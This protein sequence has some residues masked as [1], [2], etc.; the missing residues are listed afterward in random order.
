MTRLPIITFIF[1]LAVAVVLAAIMIVWSTLMGDPRPA[2]AAPLFQVVDVRAEYGHLVVE[3]QHFK[4]DGS[5][6]FFEHYVF[7]GREQFKRPRVT[8]ET[9]RLFLD[10]GREAPKRAASLGGEEHYLPEGRSWLRQ[11]RPYL[12][13]DSILSVVQSIHEQR[14]IT[15][16]T[17][18]QLRLTTGAL[19]HSSEDLSGASSLAQRFQVMRD[20]AYA[21][22]ESGT[23]RALGPMP[24]TDIPTGPYFGT[25][26]TFYPNASPESTSVDGNTVADNVDDIWSVYRA[27]AGTGSGDSGSTIRPAMLQSHPVSGDWHAIYRGIF[28]F[29]TNTLPNAAVISAATFALV[30]TLVVEDL[31]DASSLS[32]VTSSPSSD[33][34]VAA[35][36][37]TSL[38]STKQATDLT[39]AG[40]TADSST[41]NA[42]TLNS[43][44]RGNI[45]ES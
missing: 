19:D 15:G 37:H 20:I 29:D 45:T 23:L 24:P 2:Q 17:K 42:F 34:A 40:L 3:V 43:T 36:D 1:V 21:P 6:W 13:Q 44:G 38:G 9:G 16:W 7:Q 32:M 22:T 25:V 35:G 27:A 10:D 18:G 12:G 5:H 28:L 26:G 41:Y 30:V 33:I 31:P 4:P 11:S 14:S 8:D 39:L